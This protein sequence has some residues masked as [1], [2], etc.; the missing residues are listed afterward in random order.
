MTHKFCEDPTVS[1]QSPI[2]DKK[3]KIAIFDMLNK[4]YPLIYGTIGSKNLTEEEEEIIPLYKAFELITS[5]IRYGILPVCVFDGKSP[6]EKR[7]V[8]EKR[9]KHR[10]DAREQLL[11]VDK[12]SKEGKKLKLKSYMLSG[13]QLND[14]KK[15]ITLLGLPLVNSPHEA[16]QQ[17]AVLAEYLK[18]DSAG[19]IT[20]DFDILLFGAS[21]ILRNFGFNNVKTQ[22]IEKHVI[23]NYLLKKAN[24]YREKHNL[25]LF[26][27][28]T[29]SNFV[30]FIVLTGTDY[31]TS[32]GNTIKIHGISMEA[33]FELCAVNGFNNNAICDTLFNLA[34]IHDKE[35][36]LNS[37][38]EIVNI[39]LSAK[40]KTLPPENINIIPTKIQKNNLI[41]FL[42]KERKLDEKYVLEELNKIIEPYTVLKAIYEFK[43]ET[44]TFNSYKSYQVKYYTEQYKQGKL[45]SV[46]A[47]DEVIPIEEPIK[48][49]VIEPKKILTPKPKKISTPEPKKIPTPEP[50]KHII[51]TQKKTR[52]LNTQSLCTHNRFSGIC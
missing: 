18:D 49:I 39:Y 37:W 43:S 26:T 2:G 10:M 46:I 52:V 22:K 17:C 48:E 11:S 6:Q 34:L 42:C 47:D 40:S 12:N 51:H 4:L 5:T 3:G 35:K 36:F 21:V 33:L 27:E 23:L 16:D 19:V 24:M 7:C 45:P 20:N 30:H 28:F 31:T 50:K 32:T 8:T 41:E 14:I 1:T 15:M 13:S 29:H 44:I 9:K 38:E 25:E